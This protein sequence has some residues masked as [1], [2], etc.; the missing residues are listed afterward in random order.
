[1]KNII[2]GICV[3]L[4]FVFTGIGILGIVLPV[5]PTTPFLIL[6]AALFAKGSNRFHQWFIN[7]KLYKKY[8]EQAVTKKEM[9]KKA[10]RSVLTTVSILFLIGFFLS[11]VWYA[12]ALIVIVAVFHFYYFTA[13]IKTVPENARMKEI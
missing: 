1:M 5:L 10:K 6:A 8:M 9:T 2:N 4:G 7:T 13:R 12:K 3:G 11:P